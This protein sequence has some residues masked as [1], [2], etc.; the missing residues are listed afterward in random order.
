MPRHTGF[1]TDSCNLLIPANG[2]IEKTAPLIAHATA[3]NY[4][5]FGLKLTAIDGTLNRIVTLN[6]VIVRLRSSGIL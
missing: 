1:V 6:R 5:S 4:S 2:S 3:S